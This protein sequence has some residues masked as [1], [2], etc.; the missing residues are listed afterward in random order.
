[1]FRLG[2]WVY[3]GMLVGSRQAHRRRQCPDSYAPHDRP[4]LTH[5]PAMKLDRSTTFSPEKMFS[6][7]MSISLELDAM[8]AIVETIERFWITVTEL[9]KA[10]R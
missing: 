8:A 5:D 7:V 3:Y 2:S 4:T 6:V 9:P 10:T 1:M